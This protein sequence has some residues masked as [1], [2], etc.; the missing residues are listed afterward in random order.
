MIEEEGYRYDSL[1][2]EAW[3]ME[4]EMRVAEAEYEYLK[5]MR[6]TVLARIKGTFPGKLPDNQ[7]ERLGRA[8]GEYEQHLKGVKEAQ[9]RYGKLKA[10]W[11]RAIRNYESYRTEMSYSRE[12]MKKGII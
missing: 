11:F 6:H 10:G 8:S 4:E 2:S 9:I 12:K 5:E 1:S 7:L 3:Q